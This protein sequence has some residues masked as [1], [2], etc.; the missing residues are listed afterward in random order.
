M[1][2]KRKSSGTLNSKSNPGKLFAKKTKSSKMSGTASTSGGVVGSESPLLNDE[3]GD[4]N[5]TPMPSYSVDND[6]NLPSYDLGDE[7]LQKMENYST[8]A[9]VAASYGEYDPAI[10][11][12]PSYFQ[13]FDE[14]RHKNIDDVEN[15]DHHARAVRSSDKNRENNVVFVV[16]PMLNQARNTCV[17]VDAVQRNIN[18]LTAYMNSLCQDRR[19]IRDYFKISENFSRDYLMYKDFTDMVLKYPVKESNFYKYS[20]MMY[21]YYVSIIQNLH[22]LATIAI[23]ANYTMGS[24]QISKLLTHFINFCVG[25]FVRHIAYFLGNS[26]DN[27][28]DGYAREELNFRLNDYASDKQDRLTNYY[29]NSLINLKSYYYYK[30]TAD[31]E[32]DKNGIVE[33]NRPTI[34][35]NANYK[36]K[37]SV[38]SLDLRTVASVRTDLIF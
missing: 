27:A 38:V 4:G 32:V 5:V 2:K 24:S 8:D 14:S 13:Q 16:A 23:N 11:M 9:A 18:L 6:V 3:I 31:N 34:G 1:D 7:D 28:I 33:S 30:F 25:Q 20:D 19:S 37:Y 22:S 35:D 21:N 10:A 15:F 17:G 29:N 12:T 36:K 26:N